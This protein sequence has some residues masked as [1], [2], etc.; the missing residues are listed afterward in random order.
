MPVVIAG[1][2]RIFHAKFRFVV[3]IGG[4]AYAGF[5]KCSELTAEA[6]EIQQW[7]GGATIPAKSPGRITYADITL[8]RG[9]TRDRALF[10]WFGDVQAAG[11]N[12]GLVEPDYK[13]DLDIVQQERDASTILRWRVFAAWVKKV[14]VGDWDN[15]ADENVMESVTLAFD[16]FDLA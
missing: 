4:V 10:D 8:E 9:A 7:E 6:A 11:T 12:A 3:E 2:P 13:R 16:Y 5:N 1:A 15:S 14:K